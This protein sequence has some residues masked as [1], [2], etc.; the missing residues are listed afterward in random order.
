VRAPTRI[1]KY[2][3]TSVPAPTRTQDRKYFGCVSRKCQNLLHFD[4]LDQ[5]FDKLDQNIF[6]EV[7]SVT[8]IQLTS[9]TSFIF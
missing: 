8:D 4:S 3:N 9:V 5:H 2:A 7:L 1:L 6:V